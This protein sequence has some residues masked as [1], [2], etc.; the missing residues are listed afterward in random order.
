MP[1]I[2]ASQP[3]TGSSPDK[4]VEWVEQGLYS[5]RFVPGQKL[6]EADLINTLG[7]SRGPVREG[8]KRLH[9]KGIVELAPHRGAQVRA[10]TRREADDL[11]V[12]LEALTSLMARLAA[13]AVQRGTDGAQ[14][15]QIEDWIDR[16]RRGEIND[17]SFTGIRQ[18]L[19]ECLIL[20]GGNVEL[21]QIMP[22]PQLH[23]LRLQS[24]P[25]LDR[26][27]RQNILDEYLRILDAVLK[28]D[29]AAADAAGKAH[30]RAARKRL[31]SLPVEAFPVGKG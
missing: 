6:I 30:V 28:G 7:V 8:L 4:V 16:F 3:A 14:L 19:Y 25:Y 22:I 13:D 31:S 18:H 2:G 5:G 1:D 29:A 17:L 21:M 12:I 23:L 15:A 24:F 20:T 9:G 10:F 26:K 11:L 27:N